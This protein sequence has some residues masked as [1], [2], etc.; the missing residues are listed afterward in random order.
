[1]TTDLTREQVLAMPAGRELDALVAERVMGWTRVEEYRTR[2]GKDW[3]GFRP[4]EDYYHSLYRYSTDIAAAWE[5]LG[6]FPPT[7][8]GFTLALGQWGGSGEWRFVWGRHGDWDNI[9]YAEAAPLA[10]CRAALVMA[11][12]GEL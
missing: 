10:I 1:M 6:R 4:G 5:V 3:H 2:L 11:L 9:L 7:A 8:E 12:K